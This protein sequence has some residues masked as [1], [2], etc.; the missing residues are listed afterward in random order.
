MKNRITFYLFLMAL[1]ML[2]AVLIR[3]PNLIGKIGL[4]FYKYH[5]LR[6]FPKAL[7]TVGLVIG[8]SAII[9]EIIR[10]VVK[11]ELIKRLVAQIIL[12]LLAVASLILLAKVVMVFS[13]GT[14]SHTGIRFKFGAYLLPAIIFLVFMYAS[15]TLPRLPIPVI[16]SPVLE[17]N[18]NSDG[19]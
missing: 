15:I 18:N 1:I 5:Y 19:N 13:E 3:S 7:L 6:T 16:E 12:F 2:D 4:W 14:Y 9:A 8:I 11:R 10:Y 17:S